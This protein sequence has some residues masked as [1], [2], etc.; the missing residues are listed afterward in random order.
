[1]ILS[2]LTFA[3]IILG[4]VLWIM[5]K[6]LISGGTILAVVLMTGIAPLWPGLLGVPLILL[7][8]F[9]FASLGMIVTSISK[10]YDSF[11]YYFTLV[12]S[13]MFFFSGIFFP[14]ERLG[15]WIAPL[16]R[17][18]PLTH[19]A[20]LSRGILGGST[21]TPLLPSLVAVGLFAVVGFAV[22]TTSMQRRFMP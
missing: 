8:G 10:G 4:E 5:T 13:P 7:S 15:P 16:T 22:A 6:G 2:P 19:L 21:G 12:I 11:N 9:V 3:D 1:M 20:V 17:A 14:T 18:F